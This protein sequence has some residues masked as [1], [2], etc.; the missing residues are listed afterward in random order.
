MQ[1]QDYFYNFINGFYMMKQIPI[2]WNVI[3]MCIIV[4][5]T[6]ATTFIIAVAIQGEAH[7]FWYDFGDR[8]LYLTFTSWNIL[9]SGSLT[10]VMFLLY[11]VVRIAIIFKRNR[12]LKQTK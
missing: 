1:I 4:F 2:M 3:K 7:Q 9:Y 10:A 11:Y 5:V 8:T 6:V 12:Q